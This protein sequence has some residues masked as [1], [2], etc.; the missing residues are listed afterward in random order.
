MGSVHIV[1]E[2]APLLAQRKRDTPSSI[3]A[4]SSTGLLLFDRYSYM[5]D[6]IILLITGTLRQRQIAELRNKCHPLGSFAEMESVNI[7]STPADLYNA[8]LVDTP[9][10]M[11][12]PLVLAASYSL[13]S[14]L[15]LFLLLLLLDCFSPPLLP[16]PQPTTLRAASHRLT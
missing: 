9:L 11:A 12:V 5:I 15:L 10:G 13:S 1:L 3:K 2:T 14:I 16:L 8:V 7:A 4:V 6:N